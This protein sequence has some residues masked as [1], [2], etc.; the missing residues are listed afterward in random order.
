MVIQDLNADFDKCHYM[1]QLVVDV[2]VVAFAVL[3]L[4]AVT[5][6]CC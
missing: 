3:V 1:G 6:V 2:V 4:F 5:V